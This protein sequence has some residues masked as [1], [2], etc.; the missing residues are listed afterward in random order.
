M[1]TAST[2][3]LGN[4]GVFGGPCYLYN[5]G[6]RSPKTPLWMYAVAVAVGFAVGIVLA[7]WLVRSTPLL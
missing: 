7:L 5:Y 1:Q 2:A 4:C 6:S 3:R